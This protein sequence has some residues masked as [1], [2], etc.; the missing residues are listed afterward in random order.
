MDRI[1]LTDIAREWGLNPDQMFAFGKEYGGYGLAGDNVDDASIP[2]VMKRLLVFDFRQAN[3]KGDWRKN[4]VSESL[5]E[6]LNRKHETKLENRK[7]SRRRN[8]NK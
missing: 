8:N 5:T 3:K 6:F 4:L 7:A 2:I 1:L